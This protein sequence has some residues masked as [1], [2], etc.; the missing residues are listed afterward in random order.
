MNANDGRVE[1]EIGRLP[2]PEEIFL[3]WLL[4]LPDG[5]DIRAAAAQEIARLD[6]HRPLASG[7]KRLRALFESANECKLAKRE[8]CNLK[9]GKTTP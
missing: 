4:D 2:S 7:P 3:C 9:L 6:R 1:V 8:Q 5:A